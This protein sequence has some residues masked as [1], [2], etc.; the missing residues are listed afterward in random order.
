M[1]RKTT[2]TALLIVVG[3][4][5]MAMSA[6]PPAPGKKYFAH[7]VVEDQHGVI[8]PWYQGLNGQCDFRVRVAA[9]TLKRYPWTDKDQ[10]VMTAPHFVFNGHW[11]IRPDGTIVIDPKLSDWDNGDVG[12]R[13]ASLLRGLVEYYR[14]TGDPAAIG[15]LTL[16]ANYLLDYCQTPA[17]HAW[18]EFL[19]SCP[20]RGKAYGRA[21]PHG[22]IQL[23]VSAQVAAGLLA[24]YKLTGEP[25]YWA[26]VKRWADLLAQHCDH[27]PGAR[28][29]NRYANPEDA[30][31]D[32]RQ[33]AGVSL[34]VHFLDDVNR[35]GHAG[36]D[37]QLVRAR[38]T[39][40]R[41]LRD[42]L[43]PDWSSNPTF[44]HHFWDWLNPVATCAVPCYTAQHLMNRREAFP[45]W[46][47]DIRNSVSLF[48]CRS[49]VDPAS[50]GDVYSGAWAFPEASNCCGKS[51]Q[52]PTMATAAT[53][54][55]YAV[56][57]DS[58]WAR[59]LARRQTLLCTY[60]AHETGVVEDGVEGGAVVTGAWLNL[61]HPWPLRST[62]EM[63]AWQPET[64]G[65][66]R[67]NH[68][69][70][71]TAVV[72]HVRYGQG[73]V[74]YTTYDA[75]PPCEEVVR[76]AFAPRSI[77]AD[78]Q[79][80][81]KA[82]KLSAN[83]Y[84]VQP[85]SNGD[86]L[87]TIRHDGSRDVVIEGDDPQETLDDDRLQYEGEWSVSES[88][89]TSGGRLHVASAAGAK[90]SINFTGN[91]VRLI[92]R[93]DPS[94]GRADV[95]LDGVKQLCV[96]DC[97]CPQTRDQQV[98]YY[99]NGLAPGQ[100]TLQVVVAGAKNP[101][102][103]GTHVYVDAVQWSAAEGQSGCGA[104]RGPAAAQRVIFGYVGRQDV[105][106]SQ[107]HAWRPATEFVMRMQTLADLVP[108]AFWT[109]PRLKDVA[110]TPDP[111]LYRYGV[112]G[113]DFTAYFTVDPTQT[114]HVR[115]K[116]CQTEPP[117]EPGWYATSIELQ[118]RE[119]VTDLD[120]AATAKG[121]GKAVDLVF[122]DVRPEHGVVAIRFWHRI[123][124]QAMVQAI[125]VLPGAGSPG[126][127]QP[128]RFEFPPDVNL[129]ANAGFEETAGG[130]V[131]RE[132]ENPQTRAAQ[133]TYQFLGPNQGIVWA[134]SDFVRHPQSG[135]PKPRT[136]KQAARTHAMEQDAHTQV[137]QDVSVRPHTPYHAA[138]WVQTTDVR[139]QG[140]GTHAAD[141][142]GLSVEEL[143]ADGKVLVRHPK[144]ALTK[145]A[146]F[147]ELSK[148]FTTSDK[149]VKVRFLL[150]TVI[151]CKW[152]QG[153][154]TYDDC[155][156]ARQ[157]PP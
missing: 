134:E 89:E 153:H 94:G 20:T 127:A 109:E 157:P 71:T 126:G 136:G 72:R 35:S 14:Y 6:E 104:G 91:Q 31:W 25:R 8:S 29:W 88:P 117:P 53:L 11:S 74:A 16:T 2:F 152:D 155:R 143:G 83:G 124:G 52:Y 3:S 148:T 95:F 65:P 34:I 102:S 76:L 37:D 140:F 10:A 138:V 4:L 107:G 67:E 114:Y 121:L 113:R 133:W 70:R 68:L 84:T 156:L 43:L 132:R 36:Q 17:D 154:V 45:H 87:V 13:S 30:K 9:E 142:A 12:Q 116:F 92:G 112:H 135:L 97:W 85:L 77:S 86:C 90:A 28:P 21:D 32:T 46:K 18:P 63:L 39:G 1:M 130:A 99:K 141:S 78:G 139:G 105:V 48:F 55:R 75:Q 33:T 131:G 62:L 73:R 81:A 147:T 49:S 23:D 40:E 98:L 146:D 44:G 122:T 144:V 57:A 100:H 22:F 128:V 26:A 5:A 47:T 61:A 103:Q 50:A 54:A 120:I 79:A 123:S 137:F 125:E 56:L 27:Q 80:L 145:A 151:G 93:A 66:N 115:L 119:V 15:M 41:Y 69:M 42:T 60:D 64:M 110:N 106:D 150:D 7:A 101:L 96:L 19:I 38:D 51:L 58:D 111:E 118:Q 129:L 59:E 24:A 149:T 82:E 108:A